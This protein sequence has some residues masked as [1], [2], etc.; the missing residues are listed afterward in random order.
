MQSTIKSTAFALAES[1]NSLD[2]DR[3]WILIS[4]AQQRELTDN[5]L[6]ELQRMFLRV[7]LNDLRVRNDNEPWTDATLS[8]WELPH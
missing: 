2:M 1:K 4:S 8:S 5:E 6:A 3:M 7:A